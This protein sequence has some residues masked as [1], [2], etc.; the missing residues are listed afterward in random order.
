MAS[1]LLLSQPA[2][3]AYAQSQQAAA[4]SSQQL[5]KLGLIYDPLP[6]H[7]APTF[8]QLPG[9]TGPGNVTFS[10]D[11]GYNASRAWPTGASLDQ[12]IK[13]GDLQ[14]NPQL[15]GFSKLKIKDFSQN[16]GTDIGG[17]PLKDIELLNGVNLQQLNKLYKLDNVKVKDALPAVQLFVSA[18]F[19]PQGSL[20]QVR[21]NALSTG[22]KVLVK[23]LQKNPALKDVP[24]ERILAG[25]WRGSIL[26]GEKVL[27][28]EVGDKIP[29][30]LRRLP[31]GSLTVD[32]IEQDFTSLQNTAIN[33]GI[34]ELQELTLNELLTEFPEIQDVPL[35]VVSSLANQP[36]SQSL[37][38]LADATIE[39]LE[40]QD[41][42]LSSIPGLGDNPVSALLGDL[43]FNILA[44]DVFAK[45]D[46]AYSGQDGA[47]FHNGRPLS[48]G[49]RDQKFK[50][51]PGIRSPT[52]KTKS[53]KG[54]PRIEVKPAEGGSTILGT[55]PL[56]G[57]EWMTRD[58][59]VP[60]C[61]GL[62]CT[63]GKWEPAGIKPVRKSWVKFSI[64]DLKEYDDK[65][66][67]ARVYVDTQ[68]CVT[69]LFTEHCTKHFISVPTPWKLTRNSL[70]PVL[71]KRRVQD[72]FPGINEQGQ[73]SNFCT[74]GN[75]GNQPT[76]SS[77]PPQ[78]NKYGHLAYAEAQG[79]LAQVTSVDGVTNTLAPDA[80][81][82][83]E[84]MVAA[85]K[86]QG[87]DIQ[88]VSG[89]R[90]VD[91]QQQLWDTKVAKVGS[92]QEAAK[93]S[94][95]PGHSEHHTGYAVD[96]G[97]ARNPYLNTDWAQTKEYAWMQANAGQ[98]GFE[99]SFPQGNS[100]GVSFEPWHWRYTGSSAA[101]QAFANV[102][103]AT[104]QQSGSAPTL[105]SQPSG[106]TLAPNLTGLKN[107]PG[108]SNTPQQ[109]GS[110]PK[111][112]DP[113]RNIRQYLARIALGESSGGTDLGPHP[114]TGA[115]GEYQFIPETRRTILNRYGVDAWSTSKAERDQATL[116]LIRDFSGQVGADIMGLIEAG[117]FAAADV[118]L[119]RPVPGKT[120]FGQFTSLPGGAEASKYWND[121]ATLA[122]YGPSGDAGTNAPLLARNSINCN[123][124]LLAS[125]GVPTGII[126]PEGNGIATGKFGNPN[127]GYPVT[128]RYGPRSLGWHGGIDLG[129]PIGTPVNASDGG[130]VEEIG[131][132]AGGYG[133][134]VVINHKNGYS[135]LY[136]HLSE[137]QVKANQKVTKNRPI[138][139]SGETG[140]GTGPHLH[141]E[142]IRTVNGVTPRRG[143]TINPE[144]LVNF[145]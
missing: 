71:S 66:F 3:P 142:V 30:H 60:G 40:V 29:D 133:N 19:D 95:P 129:T 108:I 15:A 77:S 11:V 123:P 125:A 122:Q 134:F 47:E 23:K 126:Q 138:A 8:N 72:L 135:T 88:A 96:V 82:A 92:A 68:F 93:T 139:L 141:F 20:K 143:N 103:T 75:F 31:I 115:Y 17:V 120:K 137:V 110:A 101:K 5:S 111:K 130:I 35:S 14:N 28:K 59:K 56:L 43:V 104:A 48:G 136:A 13:I 34:N 69:I 32:I 113:Q 46:I 144:F 86:A 132:E 25:D 33:Y 67:T 51:E 106:A 79:D 140:R 119:G 54:M 117:D 22:A 99:L 50:P 81:Q 127:P 9:A 70:F 84:N 55:T 18:V 38:K 44:G 41:K 26:E 65:A 94:A 39:E 62:L 52:S 1:A 16:I 145:N 78:G 2:L 90:S 116:A 57:K 83:F 112:N 124:T 105:A 118:L 109:A 128:S 42:L 91:L 45:M 107:V 100:Q 53:T 102:N 12:V 121:P 36:L 24:F 4:A 97:N 131:Y 64:G 21:K 87:L 6:Q 98:F 74:N 37:P 27:L 58:Q 80:A 73:I 10:Q 61:K 7:L 114:D 76:A 85:A 49:T 63:F 89:F